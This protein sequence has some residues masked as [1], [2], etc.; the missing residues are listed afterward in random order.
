MNYFFKILKYRLFILLS[1]LL[2]FISLDNH[3]QTLKSIRSKKK[4]QTNLIIKTKKLLDEALSNKNV[5]L[6]QLNII[7][8]QIIQNKDLIASIGQEISLLNQKVKN[9]EKLL[10]D[11]ENKLILLKD[12][13]GKI[14]YIS[15][16]NQFY[17]MEFAYLLASQTFTQFFLRLNY[18]NQYRTERKKQ[19]VK[20]QKLKSTLAFYKKDLEKE[21]ETKSKLLKEENDQIKHLK[22]LVLEE[23][24]LLSEALKQENRFKQELQVLQTDI[25][26]LKKIVIS[27]IK[28]ENKKPFEI[29][30]LP[31]KNNTKGIKPEKRILEVIKPNTNQHFSSYKKRLNWPIDNPIIIQKF[32]K[33]R[34]PVFKNIWLEN[35]GIQI[36]SSSES[37]IKSIFYGKVI[38]ITQSSNSK[39][40]IIIKHEN[41]FSVYGNIDKVLTA[42]GE[43]VEPEKV[44]GLFLERNTNKE[45]NFQI[46]YKK[47]KLDPETWLKNL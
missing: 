9:Q 22:S 18:L 40:I 46:W 35:L 1:I 10:Q 4:K 47:I 11:L 17:L 36:K 3:A 44:I 15:S 34:H 21:Y 23:Q 41:Y 19:I 29:K 16:K 28:E 39:Y 43:F 31:K 24:I 26:N 20:I 6:Q 8:L 2:I 25:K 5:S 45:L 14:I 30:T 42:R 38:S 12:E 13:Y 27:Y 7:N 37:K 32:G 33:Y